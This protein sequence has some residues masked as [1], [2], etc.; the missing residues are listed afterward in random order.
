MKQATDEKDIINLLHSIFCGVVNAVSRKAICY[1]L[2]EFIQDTEPGLL[3]AD[4]LHM[5]PLEKSGSAESS[6]C[7]VK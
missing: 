4:R 2:S 5:K 3:L 6:V 7:P 1:S